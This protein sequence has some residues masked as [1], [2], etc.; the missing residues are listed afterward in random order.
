MK[1]SLFFCSSSKLDLVITLG[2][3]ETDNN[4]QMTTLTESIYHWVKP[5]LGNGPCFNWLYSQTDNIIY[6]LSNWKLSLLS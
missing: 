1:W 6:D 3:K 5:L 2:Q 4:N